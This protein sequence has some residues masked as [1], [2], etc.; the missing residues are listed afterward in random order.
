MDRMEETMMFKAVGEE[1]FLPG[2]FCRKCM[3]LYRKKG[4]ILLTKWLAISCP[5]TLYIL[6][7]TI[8]RVR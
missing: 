2:I 6:P 4:M 7:A 1:K 3:Q 5:A 8:M